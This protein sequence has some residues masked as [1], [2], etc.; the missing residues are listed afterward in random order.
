ML[1]RWGEGERSLAEIGERGHGRL[2]HEDGLAREYKEAAGAIGADQLATIH[3]YVWHHGEP[4]RGDADSRRDRR[5]R[6]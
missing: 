6:R 3:L 4:K 5:Q 2:M 1:G